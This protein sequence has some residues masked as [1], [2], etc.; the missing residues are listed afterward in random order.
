MSKDIK[1]Q[2]PTKNNKK[3]IA[4][5]LVAILAVIGIVMNNSNE[6]K[7]VATSTTEP[8]VTANI[9]KEPQP[10]EEPTVA[11]IDISTP[12]V[13]ADEPQFEV[14]V[15]GAEEPEKQAAW[16]PKLGYQGVVVQKEGNEGIITVRVF[17]D[18]EIRIVLRGP[19]KRDENNQTIENWVDF[20]SVQI[21][22][23]EILPE[24][25]AVWHNKPF[26]H[27]INAKA[28]DEVKVSAKWQ[29][30]NEE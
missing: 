29:K 24:I 14:Y 3:Y 11:R 6:E 15:D 21:N 1:T 9:N 17:S 2:E 12:L 18:A 26:R 23:E 16:M 7:T 25:T 4:L 8:E 13:N 22:G 20:T 28:G 30:H 19:D 5:A 27:T 10:K